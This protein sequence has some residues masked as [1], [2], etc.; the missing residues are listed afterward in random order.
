VGFLVFIAGL[1]CGSLIGMFGLRYIFFHFRP[2]HEEVIAEIAERI[3]NDFQLPQTVRPEMEAEVRSLLA[4]IRDA[5]A[6]TRSRIDSLLDER[7]ERLGRFM[8]DGARL[9]RWMKEYTRYFRR[10]PP[11]PPP[12]QPAPRDHAV[13]EN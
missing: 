1:V 5:M 8:P 2:T 12:P 11:F 4:S 10:P 6:G 7:A 13:E 3:I 9:E